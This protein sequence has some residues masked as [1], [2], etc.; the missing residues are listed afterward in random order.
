MEFSRGRRST[1]GSSLAPISAQE[2]V[3]ARSETIY[4][5]NA[6]TRTPARRERQM[7]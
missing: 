4:F 5:E 6:V 7:K 3:A 1:Y 2:D